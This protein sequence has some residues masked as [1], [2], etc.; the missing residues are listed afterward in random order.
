MDFCLKKIKSQYCAVLFASYH[1]RRKMFL[2][3]SP[4]SKIIFG[5]IVRSNSVIK[6][7]A[8]KI[9]FYNVK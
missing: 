2:K 4:I 8:I 1:R 9:F 5:N 6:N 3:Y 7:S